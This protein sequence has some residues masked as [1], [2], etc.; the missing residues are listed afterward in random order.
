MSIPE[1]I[2]PVQCFV[3]HY[4]TKDMNRHFLSSHTTDT[5]ICRVAA[6]WND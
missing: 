2:Y 6:G 1:T 5:N 3:P 4:F